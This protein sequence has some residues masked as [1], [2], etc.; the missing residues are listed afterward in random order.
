[1]RHYRFR[2]PEGLAVSLGAFQTRKDTF[3]D[4]LPLHRCNLGDEGNEPFL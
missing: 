2:A 4:P 3:P 1:M